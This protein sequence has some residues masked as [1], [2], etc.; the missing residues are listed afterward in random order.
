MAEQIVSSA[1]QRCAQGNDNL[2]TEAPE[3]IWDME[4]DVSYFF[5]NG[6]DQCICREYCE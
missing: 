4:D 2:K 1:Q 5:K 6:T 3:K